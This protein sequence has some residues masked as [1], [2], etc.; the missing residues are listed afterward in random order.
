MRSLIG[1][2]GSVITLIAPFVQ[3][4]RA[5]DIYADTAV[6]QIEFGANDIKLVLESHGLNVD[7][8][9]LPNAGQA[10]GTQ[11]VLIQLDESLGEQAYTIDCVEADRYVVKGGDANGAMYGALRLAELFTSDGFGKTYQEADHPRLLRRGIKFN[12]P[13]DRRSPTYYGNGFSKLSFKGDS[14]KAAIKDVWDFSF[15]ESWFDEMARYRYNAI[16]LWSLHPFTSLISMPD[17]P[18]VAIQDVQGFDGFSKKLSIDEKI[19]FWRKVMKYAKNRGFEVYFFNWNIYTYGATGKYGISNDPKSPGLKKY[20]RSCVTRLFET[21]PDLSGFGVTAGENTQIGDDEEEARWMWDVYG[22]GILDFAKANPDRN[23]VFIHRY[24][25]A[26]SEALSKTFKPMYSM[27]NVRF[28]FSNKYA[29]AHI[30]SA[31]RPQWIRSRNGDIPA[32]LAA[33]NLKTWIELRN[34]SFYYLHWGNPDFVRSYLAGFP[35]R[36]NIVRGFVMGADGYTATYDLLSKA[37]WAEGMLEVRRHWYTYM[38]WGRL[39]YNPEVPDSVFKKQME[40]R[41]PSLSPNT[42]FEAWKHASLGVPMFTEVIQGTWKA[43][44]AWWPE[45]CVGTNTF[46]TIQ[47][48]LRTEPPPGAEVCSIKDAA[49]GKNRGKRTPLETADLIE[50]HANKALDLIGRDGQTTGSEEETT[51]GNILAFSYLSIA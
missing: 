39:G 20:M 7:L 46:R 37:P 41:Y 21:Y 12:I 14:T 45:A 43:D 40:K 3:T 11:S 33:L 27:P 5:I 4:A 44:Y 51:L 6:G 28:E 49:A 16:T 36:E 10:A 42:L 17:Y 48:M 30:Y 15:W 38:L 50:Q 19:E 2:I 47:Q 35:D 26:S 13:W 31:V 24:H 18:N 32:Q 34:D 9:G 25:G 1:V 29:V 23:I 22:E 8:R